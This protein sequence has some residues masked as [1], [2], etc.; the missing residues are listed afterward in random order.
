MPPK[1]HRSLGRPYRQCYAES[2]YRNE[3]ETTSE[4]ASNRNRG[5]EREKR[6][7][8]QLP[9]KQ[10][11]PPGSQ[12]ASTRLLCAPQREA[13]RPS[14]ANPAASSSTSLAPFFCFVY[15]FFFSFSHPFSFPDPVSSLKPPAPRKN[16]LA[17]TR[18]CGVT[19]QCAEM[20]GGHYNHHQLWRVVCLP[21]PFLAA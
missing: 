19:V 18:H 14:S 10:A 4:R 5:G 7:Q 11:P 17:E 13:S 20:G 8:Q 1:L 9:S 16:G 21:L 2:G 15:T 3:T 6:Q 12:P